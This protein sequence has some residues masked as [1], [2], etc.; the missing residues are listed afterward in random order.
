MTDLN[1]LFAVFPWVYWTTITVFGLLVGSFLNVVAYRLPIMLER[2][3]QFEAL[4][5]LASGEDAEE[6]RS[7]EQDAPFNLAVPRSRCPHCGHGIRWYENVPVVSYL[8]LRGRCS[9][10]KKPISAR[11]PVV[12]LST[13]LI[14]LAVALTLPWSWALLLWLVFAWALIALTLIDLDTQLLPDQITLPLLW[15]GLLAQVAGLLPA[16]TLTDAVTG[17]AAGYLSLWLVF[18]GFRLLTGKDGMGYGDFKLFAAFGAWFGWQALPLIILLSSVVGA[19]TGIAMLL[20]L[21]RDKNI[22][23]AFGPYLCG[24]AL[25]YFWFGDLL[26]SSYLRWALG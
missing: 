6:T 1:S 13:G 24:A 7:A 8:A 11:Y 25:I 4:M 21:G 16:V 3:W 9:Q 18:H 5:I 19:V 17:A 15:L 14:S 2:S 12:E 10:C 26:M 20:L 23:I 22:P